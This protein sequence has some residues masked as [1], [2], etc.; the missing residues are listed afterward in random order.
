VNRLV[1]ASVTAMCLCVAASLPAAVQAQTQDVTSQPPPAEPKYLDMSAVPALTPDRVRKV[2]QALA[3]KGF[4]AGPI[5]GI[6]GPMT[7]EAV[8]KYQDQYGIKPTG[9]I[10]NQTLYALGGAE[11]ASRPDGN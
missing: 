8:R 11:L 3:R 4:D 6:L 7:K 9:E 1:I 10:D 2:Q 5:D